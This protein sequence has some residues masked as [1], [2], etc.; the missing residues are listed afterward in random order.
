M[1]L[2]EKQDLVKAFI[3]AG[4]VIPKVVPSSDGYMSGMYVAYELQKEQSPRLGMSLTPSKLCCDPAGPICKN[5]SARTGEDWCAI[6]AKL[7][8]KF[9][10]G[11]GQSPSFY[12]VELAYPIAIDRT[13]AYFMALVSELSWDYA[14]A[15]VSKDGSTVTV[16][17]FTHPAAGM[18]LCKTDP[19]APNVRLDDCWRRLSLQRVPGTDRMVTDMWSMTWSIVPPGTVLPPPQ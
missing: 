9:K 14:L 10:A 16:T 11:T 1:S 18:G 17:N 15:E 19:D 12:N 2:A 7:P 5:A 3:D 4:V 6:V 8:K 13:K